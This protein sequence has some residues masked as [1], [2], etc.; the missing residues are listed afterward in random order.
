MATDH[1]HG[2]EPALGAVNPDALKAGHEP[3]NTFAVKPILGVP[4][5]VVVTFVI[6]FT[7]AA[8]AFAYWSRTETDR[9]AHPEAVEAAKKGTNDRLAAIDRAGLHKN[10]LRQ[11]DQ[12]RLEPLKRL[13]ADGMYHLRVPMP[14]GNSPE[15]H[16]EEIKPDRVADLQTAGYADKDHKFAKIPIRDAMRIAV[17]DK[18]MFPVAKN[19]SKP[20]PTADKPSSSSGGAGVSPPHAGAK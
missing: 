9:Y 6:A 10:D 16:P 7:V 2:D 11:V 20:T 1:G 18:A 13:E 15:I 17:A 12:P 19:G 5:A 8:G 4:L 3:D 14:T